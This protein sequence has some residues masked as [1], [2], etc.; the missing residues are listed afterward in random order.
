MRIPIARPMLGPEERQGVLDVLESGHFRSGRRVAEFEQ[1]FAAFHGARYGVALSSG[2]AALT[3]ALVAHG[4]GRG[5]EVIVPSFSFF[6]TASAV[7][8]AG[9]TPVFGDID[10]TTYC[11][12]PA[13]AAATITARTRAILLVHL[14]G[15]PGDLAAMRELCARHAL[16]LLEDAAQ[17]HGAAIGEC[18]V[19]ARGTAAF[20][21]YATKN[22]TTLEG[23]MVLTDDASVDDRIRKLRDHG[24]GPSGEHELVGG[25]QRMNELSAAIGCA[26]LSRLLDFNAARSENAHHYDR[27]LRGVAPPVV[28]PGHLHVFHQYTVRAPSGSERDRLLGELHGR[29]IE[30]HV[31]YEKPIHRQAAVSELVRMQRPELPE[32]ERAT[33]EVL[34]LP[35]FAGLR[36]DERDYV[37]EAVNA[38]CR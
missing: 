3:A 38:A 16:L 7:L 32:T 8:A 12:S 2:T 27:Y 33:R 14:F 4:I 35:V 31:Y 21:F 19:G 11:L 25:N 20:S 15:L 24:R 22:M 37:V 26:Q 13:A 29:G 9:A 36:V 34:S 17:A 10:A 5:D 23:G 30:A 1:A 28:P 6:A 18:R